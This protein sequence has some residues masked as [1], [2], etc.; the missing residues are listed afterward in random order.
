MHSHASPALV[1]LAEAVRDKVAQRMKEILVLGMSS[2]DECSSL[3]DELITSPTK[4]K[5]L[6]SEKLK[7]SDSLVWHCVV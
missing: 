4:K 7:I 2:M 5:A 1:D 3:E 6:K